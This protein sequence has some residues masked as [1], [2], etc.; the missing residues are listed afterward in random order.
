MLKIKDEV[1][2]EELKKFGFQETGSENNCKY[3]TYQKEEEETYWINVDTRI[4]EIEITQEIV[5]LNNVL[6]DLIQAG[7]LEKV[8]DRQ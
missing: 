8:S 1:D 4:I 7:I 6:Y 3:F 2:L 5:I